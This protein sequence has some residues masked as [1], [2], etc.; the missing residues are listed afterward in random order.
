VTI[1][2]VL[3]SLALVTTLGLTACTGTSAPT[4]TPT[5]TIYK[6]VVRRE[7]I[8]KIVPGPVRTVIKYVSRSEVRTPPLTAGGAA[9]C[10]RFWESGNNYRAQNPTS[11]ASGGYQFLDSTWQYVTG[12]PG[13]AMNYP[14][15]TQDSAFWKLWD[16]GRGASQWVTH[17]HCV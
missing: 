12:L 6:Y 15:A 16:N 14:P 10:I 5:K 9:A 8:V 11:S 13:R 4:P 1:R 7:T 2:R 17:S 3:T